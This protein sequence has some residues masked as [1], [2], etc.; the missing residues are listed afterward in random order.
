MASRG[1]SG[2][3]GASDDHGP[4]LCDPADKA[5]LEVRNG[6][7]QL[8]YISQLVEGGSTQL[9]ESHIRQL[10]EIAIRDIYPCGGRYRDAR[11][12]VAISN[13]PH[14]LP[15]AVFVPALVQEA[16]AFINDHEGK[17]AIDRAAYALW[18]I[19]WIHPFAG[20]NGRTSRAVAYLI[21][22]MDSGYMLPG[23]PTMPSL[24]YDHRRQYVAALRET[25]DL[26]K[27]NDGAVDLTPMS[28]F[29][30]KMVVRQLAS[31]V[32]GL[33]TPKPPPVR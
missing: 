1:A 10:Q 4:L 29:L 33:D 30:R 28:T 12:R 2:G 31:V 9:R 11:K 16:V 25:D 15:E 8:E 22:C 13:S 6:A 26:A 27:A 7:E 5:R 18:R 14:V 17:S 21:I 3:D 32:D 20:G 19:N 24:I 23:V